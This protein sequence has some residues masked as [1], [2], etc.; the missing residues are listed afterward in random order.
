MKPTKLTLAPDFKEFIESFNV[1]GVRYLVVGGFAVG[2]HG[3]PRYTKDIDVWVDN[4]RENSEC[5]IAALRR[6]GFGALGL[7]ADDFA[8][9]DEIIQLG[10]APVRIDI[11]T[12]VPGLSFSECY[13]RRDTFESE[14]LPIDT[15]CVDDLI[16]S[17]K[18]AGRG[19]DLGDV[20]ELL[21]GRDDLN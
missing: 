3:R 11:L 1:E 12:D 4:S 14:G 10:V 2:F 15:V 16:T 21:R 20:D 18:T 6:F 7:T 19:V 5:V 9:S 8:G 13:D 17:K